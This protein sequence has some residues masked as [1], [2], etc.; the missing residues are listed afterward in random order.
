MGHAIGESI[1]FAIGVAISPV[2]IIAIVLMLLSKKSGANSV[3]FAFGWVIGVAGVT[4]VVI[5]AAGPLERGRVGLPLTAC[6]L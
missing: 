6:P 5:A 3:A 2:P 1:T 4:A